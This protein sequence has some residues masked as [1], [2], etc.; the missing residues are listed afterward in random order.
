M[1]LR[2]SQGSQVAAFLGGLLVMS[3]VAYGVKTGKTVGRFGG[4]Y[5]AKNPVRFWVEIA[6]QCALAA[7]LFFLFANGE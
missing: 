3:L 5:R 2:S 1:I 6:L 7:F 4:F